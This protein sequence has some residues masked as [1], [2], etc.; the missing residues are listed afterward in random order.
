MN[1]IEKD[2]VYTPADINAIVGGGIHAELLSGWMKGLILDGTMTAGEA[3]NFLSPFLTAQAWGKL[4]PA[5]NTVPN[6]PYS[7]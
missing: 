1:K 5:D 7:E 4:F 6:Q 2:K 3:Y